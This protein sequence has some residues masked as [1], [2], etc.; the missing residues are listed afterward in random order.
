MIVIFVLFLSLKYNLG[1]GTE[2]SALALALGGMAKV[3]GFE[4]VY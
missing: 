4:I 2:V 3:D 1:S